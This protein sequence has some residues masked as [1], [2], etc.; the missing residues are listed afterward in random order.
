M[1]SDE[2]IE[3][4]RDEGYLVVPDLLTPE[5]VE[6]FLRNEASALPPGWRDGLRSH[7][8]N[9]QRMRL[10]SHPKV[11][12][13]VRALLGGAPQIVQTMLL[14]KPPSGGQGIALHQDSY[15]IRN[16]PNTLMAC[17][18][19]L[20]DTDAENGGL[21]V[22]PGSHKRG[23]VGSHP[24]RDTVEHVAWEVEHT[25]RDREGR[26]WTHRLYAAEVDDLDLNA[27]KKLTV[28]AGGGVFFTGLTIHGSFSNRTPH[29]RRAAFATHYVKDGTWVY[30]TD[31][32]D[33]APVAAP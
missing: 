23:L 12:A 5:E 6:D 19:A 13:V 21:C 27:L 1:I 7:A 10:A 20:T 8:L 26:E 30:R 17:W 11:T 15:Y 31:I 28:P 4:Y 9:P 22:V 14:D 33:L 2:Q 25:L 16:E 18:L 32:Q 3:R 24:N 29:R